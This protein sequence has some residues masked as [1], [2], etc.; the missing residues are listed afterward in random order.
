MKSS[1]KAGYLNV[2][3]LVLKT[4]ACPFP[5]RDERT[6]SLDIR[7]IL[8]IRIDRVGDMVLSTPVF[9]ALKETWPQAHL[10]VLASPAN[11]PVL[12][13]NPH[14]DEVILY[15]Q[16]ASLP[17]KMGRILQLRS[18]RFD[19]AIDLHADEALATAFLA[20]ASRATR[21]IG[22]AAFGRE[23]FFNGPV[24]TI[25]KNRHVL[26]SM[27]GLLKGIGVESRNDRKPGLYISADEKGW[28]RQWL[29]DRGLVNHTR[30]AI[31]PG[32]H[33]ETQRWPVEYHARLIDLILRQTEAEVILLGSPSDAGV[34]DEIL[35]RGTGNVHVCIQDDL[36]KFLAILSQCRMLVCNNS[37][38]LHCAAALDIPTLSFMGPTVRELWMPVGEIHRVFRR[39]ELPC[40]GCNSG[41][42]RIG[43]H[44]CMSLIR[45]EAAFEIIR[46]TL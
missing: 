43:T 26:D 14:V 36:R 39:D 11:A 27:L 18:R 38:P 29:D 46:N 8:C 12:E 28:A 20:A 3:G 35:T 37:G 10:V 7:R 32:A 41:R 42:C 45:P 13:H 44:D 6:A 4:L 30:I 33:Y 2:R 21:R 9:Q 24:V 17:E 15:D 19:L 34:V 16:R 1:L 31:H 22:F 40:I 5:K 25:E 23:V